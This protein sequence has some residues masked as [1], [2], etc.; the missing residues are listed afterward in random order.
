MHLQRQL[1][2]TRITRGIGQDDQ[3]R[4]AL[5][6]AY[7]EQPRSGESIWMPKPVPLERQGTQFALGAIRVRR[8]KSVSLAFPA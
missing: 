7:Q 6:R 3:V 1:A 4:E 8:E 5:L 2:T